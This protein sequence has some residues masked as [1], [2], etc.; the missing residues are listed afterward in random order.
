[1]KKIFSLFLAVAF[2]FVLASCDSKPTSEE[3]ETATVEASIEEADAEEV[4]AEE[5]ESETEVEGEETE[6]TQEAAE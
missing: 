4:V 3:S 5:V 2:M 1:M 6:A